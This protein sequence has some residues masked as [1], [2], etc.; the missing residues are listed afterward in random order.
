VIPTLR[1]LLLFSLAPL[2]LRGADDAREAVL[3]ADAARVDAMIRND[4][5]A[6]AAS[7]SDTV[8]YGHSD[9]RLQNKD[10]LLAALASNRIQYQS[11][12]YLEREVHAVGEARAVTGVAAFRVTAEGRP[13]EFTL[14]FLA[15][16]TFEDGA[17]RLGAYQSTPLPPPPR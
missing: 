8:R 2:L 6:V 13:L 5:A 10:Q 17:W 15:V 7:L 12:H 4:A 1:L 14:R 11:V 3:A 9:G 16:Y